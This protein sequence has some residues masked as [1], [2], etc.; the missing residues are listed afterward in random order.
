MG[1]TA[2]L[3][4]QYDDLHIDEGGARVLRGGQRIELPPKAF[5]LL[6]AL[7]RQAGRTVAKD[8]LLEAAWGAVPEREAVLKATISELRH[9]LGDDVRR[10]RYIET[11]PRR[12]YRFVALPTPADDER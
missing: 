2:A 1:D 11:V 8:V 7:A 3:Q 12:G 9:A 10:P 5:L 6:C 4:S